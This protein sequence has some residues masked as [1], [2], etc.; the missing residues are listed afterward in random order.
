MTQRTSLETL[1]R[2]HP[3]ASLKQAQALLAQATA[4]KCSTPQVRTFLHH[5]GLRCRRVETIPS[6]ADK[7]L[8]TSRKS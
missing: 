1:L 5:L 3:P 7:A 2:Q 4:R 8:K 6:Q